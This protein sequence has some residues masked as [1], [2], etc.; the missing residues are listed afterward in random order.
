MFLRLPK[1]I[2]RNQHLNGSGTKTTLRRNSRL[3]I[4]PISKEWEGWMGMKKGE[5][6]QLD[7]GWDRLMNMVGLGRIK[8]VLIGHR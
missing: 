1:F 3:G 6:G 5:S 4:C 8:H 2:G 7:S